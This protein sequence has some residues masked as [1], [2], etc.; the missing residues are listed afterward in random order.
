IV[1]H[2]WAAPGGK[3][4]TGKDYRLSPQHY[5]TIQGIDLNKA[6]LSGRITIS[7]SSTS[8]DV[9]LLKNGSDSLVVLYRKDATEPWTLYAN[10]QKTQI[11]IA[12]Y[13]DIHQLKPGDYTLAN[14]AEKVGLKEND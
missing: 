7:P 4:P 14:S 9:E 8:L 11:G 10:Q 13:I 5:W 1:M 12:G 6:D 2:N 3:I